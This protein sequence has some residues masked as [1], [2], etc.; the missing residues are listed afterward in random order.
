MNVIV[1]LLPVFFRDGQI[2]EYMSDGFCVECGALFTVPT[3]SKEEVHD[4]L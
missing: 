3:P 1:P 4:D 2:A